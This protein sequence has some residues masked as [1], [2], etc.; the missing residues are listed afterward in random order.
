VRETS[1]FVLDLT[2]AKTY[3]CFKLQRNGVDL[4]NSLLLK[5]IPGL[6]SD[7]KVYLVPGNYLYLYI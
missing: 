2:S 1:Q 4:E 7:P 5:D 6:D 3:T